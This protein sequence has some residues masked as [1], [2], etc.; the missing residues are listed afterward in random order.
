MNVRVAAVAATVAALFAVLL[1]ATRSKPDPLPV[2]ERVA[3][4]RP[5]EAA[6]PL[7]PPVFSANYLAAL[8]GILDLD[9]TGAARLERALAGNAADAAARLQLMA[10]HGRADNAGD[11]V[12]RAKRFR[13]VKW[14]IEHDPGSELLRSGF[15]HFLPKELSAA[16]EQ[17]AARLWVAAVGRDPGNAAVLWNAASFF[18]GLDADLHWQYLEATVAADPNHPFALRP[19][20][21]LYALFALGPGPKASRALAA[22]EASRNVWILGNA[23]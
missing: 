4:A 17:T 18:A 21:H 15:S 2:T 1:V 13:H 20:A 10:Y 9:E 11:P 14:L 22:L 6:P 12:H 19:L 7:P 3:D 16:E 8:G 23:A 5:I